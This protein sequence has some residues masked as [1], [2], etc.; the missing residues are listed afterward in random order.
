MSEKVVGF[1]LPHRFAVEEY[2]WGRVICAG[3]G[4]GASL[5]GLGCLLAAVGLVPD[6]LEI[7][8]GALL[9]VWGVFFLPFGVFCVCASRRVLTVDGETLRYQPT[10]G[11]LRRFTSADI[12]GMQIGVD[13]RL[14]GYDGKT[15][16]RFEGNQ[17]NSQLLLLYLSDRN[18]DLLAK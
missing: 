16:A 9:A 4:V 12:A 14:V 5:A 8:S 3:F 6:W 15:L 1:A 7:G 2:W 10:F 11:K 13:Y 17:K 18:I